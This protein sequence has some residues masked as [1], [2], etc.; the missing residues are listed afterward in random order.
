MVCD[1]GQLVIE[2]GGIHGFGG[3]LD[4][5]VSGLDQPN[6]IA[7]DFVFFLGKPHRSD[8]H[9]GKVV[10]N[11][12]EESIRRDRNVAARVMDYQAVGVLGY[13]RGGLGE[14]FKVIA[15]GLAEL[16]RAIIFG[17][18][19][20]HG[21]EDLR[22]GGIEAASIRAQNGVEAIA[23]AGGRGIDGLVVQ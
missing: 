22:G 21:H 10:P 14:Q 7:Q 1:I 18:L 23:I 16:L 4:F 19:G 15:A 2:I 6:G 12:L 20:K 13:H 11:G 17:L 9:W 8:V 3:C 5:R